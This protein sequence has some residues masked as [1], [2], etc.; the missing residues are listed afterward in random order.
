MGNRNN[1]FRGTVKRRLI[2]LS[3]FLPYG[4]RS[5]AFYLQL[6]SVTLVS[7]G[8]ITSQQ[9]KKGIEKIN[10]EQKQN[11]EWCRTEL[12]IVFVC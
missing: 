10:R 12:F 2:E 9:R 7:F 8:L 1:I 3:N 5:F 6:L 4:E 11:K